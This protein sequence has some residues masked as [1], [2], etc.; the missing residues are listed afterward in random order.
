M[1]ALEDNLKCYKKVGIQYILHTDYI[2]SHSNQGYC[3]H[4]LDRQGYCTENTQTDLGYDYYSST[5]ELEW[6]SRNEYY[7]NASQIIAQGHKLV[8]FPF[9]LKG[10]K[11]E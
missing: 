2:D 9:N 11:N 3:L 7:T 8:N 10:E 4:I 5:G 6:L 1:S